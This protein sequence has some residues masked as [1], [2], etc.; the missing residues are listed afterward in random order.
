MGV[1]EQFDKSLEVLESYIPAYFRNAR[2]TYY[3]KVKKYFHE[4]K[5][6]MKKKP[7]RETINS[8]RRN[9]TLEFE[10]YQFCKQRLNLQHELLLSL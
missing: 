1:L 7:S 6:S 3:N 5:N 8:L 2:K 9:F 4:N 10:F